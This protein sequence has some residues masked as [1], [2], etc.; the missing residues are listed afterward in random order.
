MSK[1]IR[2]SVPLPDGSWYVYSDQWPAKRY[3]NGALQGA[4]ETAW[5]AKPVVWLAVGFFA[6]F[7]YQIFNVRK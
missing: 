6:S 2:I 1:E 3:K 7:Y 4:D 5:Y